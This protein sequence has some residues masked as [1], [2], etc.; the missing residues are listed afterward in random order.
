MV[1]ICTLLGVRS[2]GGMNLVSGE[3]LYSTKIWPLPAIAQCMCC[4]PTS[5]S[6]KFR[7]FTHSLSALRKTIR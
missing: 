6:Q 7:Y 3:E 4:M 2:G 1:T 5:V